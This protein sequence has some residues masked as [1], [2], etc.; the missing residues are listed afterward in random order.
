METGQGFKKL[1]I[2]FARSSSCFLFPFTC[3]EASGSGNRAPGTGVAV[4][5]PQHTLT[6][7]ACLPSW[8][9]HC[10]AGFLSLPHAI[11]P[12][13]GC[14]VDVDVAAPCLPRPARYYRPTH[15]SAAVGC[16]FILHTFCSF[17]GSSR[18]LSQPLHGIGL[19]TLKHTANTDRPQQ[20][21]LHTD[22]DDDD[23][24]FTAIL[25]RKQGCFL[26][27]VDKHNFAQAA[28][29]HTVFLLSF[30]CVDPPGRGWVSHKHNLHTKH[31]SR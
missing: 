11:L 29:A 6:L 2:A 10:A 14:C 7:P 22:G 15:P 16:T 12:A 8:L 25:Q 18:F 13:L 26:L 27:M 20:E 21:Q 28:R 31:T 23:D 3:Q 17:F 4:N 1:V 30:F 5:F 9:S 24:A 19:N